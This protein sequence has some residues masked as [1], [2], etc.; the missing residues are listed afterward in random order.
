[1]P[2]TCGTWISDRPRLRRT[3]S[4]AVIALLLAAGAAGQE[5]SVRLES[6][7]FNHG[8]DFED[9]QD[10]F[11]T[12]AFLPGPGPALGT[13]PSG[14]SDV[15]HAEIAD[16][17]VRFLVVCRGKTASSA[18][19]VWCISHTR[20]FIRPCRT[21]RT[22]QEADGAVRYRVDVRYMLTNLARQRVRIDVPVDLKIDPRGSTLAYRCADFRVGS[23]TIGGIAYR[24]GLLRRYS[25]LTFRKGHMMSIL[26]GRPGEHRFRLRAG[27]DAAGRYRPREAF[28]TDG[29][30]MVG[31]S[32][33]EIAAISPDGSR[34]V[35]RP[36]EQKESAEAGFQMP[37][38]TFET[39][40]GE[41]LGLDQLRGKTVILVWWRQA[42]AECIA[43]MTALSTLEKRFRGRDD[44]VF[45]GASPD[46]KESLSVFLRGHKTGVRIVQATRQARELL[47]MAFP[48]NIVIDRNGTVFYDEYK[49]A[50]A[51]D[52]EL[53]A[54]INAC[55]AVR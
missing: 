11:A 41:E 19:T 33:Y 47:G 51:G 9:A 14:L 53:E 10:F 18:D 23:A 32:A 43:E 39:I 34:I 2:N 31:G 48:R 5:I 52:G 28:S 30:V 17:P 26:I 16:S 1:M 4:T 12:C 25:G 21:S 50:A 36:S 15:T 45:L 35:L 3:C 6:R 7:E 49:A 38:L 46:G 54:A 20:R 27:V 13:V 24:I 8:K 37:Q 29:P 55:R 22:G 40:E 44:V 42:S